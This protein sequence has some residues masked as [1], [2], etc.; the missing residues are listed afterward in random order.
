MRCLPQR[1][2][3][4][5]KMSDEGFTVVTI[6]APLPTEKEK[7]SHCIPGFGV[8]QQKLV[9]SINYVSSDPGA[10]VRVSARASQFIFEEGSASPLSTMRIYNVVPDASEVFDLMK[11]GTRADFEGALQH[12]RCSLWDCDSAGRGLLTVCIHL[13]SMRICSTYDQYSMQATT[14][15]SPCATF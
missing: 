10:K 7:E 3:T 11:N 5:V 2:E 12:G 6:A 1:P 14:K 8:L 15:I 9:F 13:G 4:L